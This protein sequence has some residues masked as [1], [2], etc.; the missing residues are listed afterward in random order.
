MSERQPIVRKFDNPDD[1]WSTRHHYLGASE[2]ATLFGHGYQSYY[3]LWNTKAGNIDPENLDDVFPVIV[4]DEME[5]G[6]AN[7][8][9]RS[10]EYDLRKSHRYLIHWSDP[11]RLACSLDYELR[12][13]DAGWVPAEL[14]ILDYSSFAEQFEETERSGEYDPPLKFALQLQTQLLITGKPYGYIFA[15][16]S[17]RQ[18]IEI[19]ME[20]DKDAQALIEDNALLFWQS[21]ARGDCPP[22]EY[23]TD[24]Q[25]MYHVMTNVDDGREVDWQMDDHA[26]ELLAAYKE[27]SEREK[28]SK[29][30][31][32]SIRA[33]V[34]DRMGPA[35]RAR[36]SNGT[37]SAKLTDRWGKERRELRITTRK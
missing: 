22:P 29:A 33:E 21:I 18:L 1:Y 9:R 25:T 24:L 31:K 3:Q 12:T 2:V 35:I 7:V 4:G 14:K 27:A 20:A 30:I 28:G 37:I 17:N 5:S 34:L 6:L 26:T 15:L 11:H 36:C 23:D 8:I 19:R 13:A 32:D 16:V 10:R